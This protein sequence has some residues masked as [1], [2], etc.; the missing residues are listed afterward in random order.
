VEPLQAGIA[1]LE[2]ELAAGLDLAGTGEMGI[3][4][5][6]AASAMVAALTGA[7]VED[8][9]GPGTGVDEAGRRRKVDAISRA[10]DDHGRARADF[11]LHHDSLNCH[12]APLQA[13]NDQIAES[14][15]TALAD[16]A[17]PCAQGGKVAGKNRR[18]SF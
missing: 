8:V 16:K 4:N 11:L 17:H 13:G 10:L 7:A 1:L 2:T 15:F 3:G 5:T 12:A 18:G 14:I 9:T 6:T